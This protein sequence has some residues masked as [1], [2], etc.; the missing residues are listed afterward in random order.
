MTVLK[1][2]DAPIESRWNREA[3]YASWEDWQA[4]YEQTVAALPELSNY[5][6]RLKEG[7]QVLA[8]WF[9]VYAQHWERVII[10]SAFAGWAIT[11]DTS[12]EE[13]R[14]YHSQSAGLESE[15]R[16]MAAFMD[17][18]L[19]EIGDTLLDWADKEEKLARFRHYFSNLLR[20]RE[21]RRSAE[22]E[23][24]LNMADQ[25]FEGVYRAYSELVN[26][27][28]KFEDAI[29][30]QGG[31]HPIFQATVL[32]SNES[33]DRERRLSA[34][35]NY[36]DS[37]ISMENTLAS[38]Y[39]ANVKQQIFLMKA[40][41]FN[42]VL[43]MRL[44]PNNLPVE[45][46]HNLINTFKKNLPLWR[47]Y[48]QAKGKVL[49]LAEMRPY[50]ILAPIQKTPPKI[51]YGQ[52][53]EWI[54]AA[55]EPMGEDYVNAMRRGALEDRWV[56]YAPNI[57][58]RQGAASSRQVGRK[59]P[60]IFMSYNDSVINLS[61]LAHELGHSMHSRYFATNQPFVYNDY[62]AISSTVTETASNFNQAMTRAYL[63]KEKADD[64]GL[65]L[66]MVDEAMSNFYR[67]FFVM[68][69]LARFEL[70]VYERAQAGK[71]LTTTDLKEIMGRLFGEGYGETLRDD[72]ERTAITWAKFL[73]LYIPF[74]SFQYAI[75]ISA[76]HAASDKILLGEEGAVEGYQNFLKAG[77]SRYA[78]DLF[79]L[80]GVDMSSAEPIEKAF[81]EMERNVELLEVMAGS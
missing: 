12:D 62:G 56:D 24:I 13:A 34:W 4:E 17:P 73:H 25:P 49:G 55:L 52:A 39:L 14:R 77:G 20:L 64:K 27:D 68:P 44:S 67:Y 9:E 72:P 66:A 58:K 65:Q 51:P 53:V 21:H 54:C 57:E 43:E 32:S 59:P 37:F 19:L 76:A 10:L 50:D 31:A 48:W 69:T 5:K 2:K 47:R 40:R 70:E 42:S 23:E 80:A 18:E 6:G 33:H 16:A 81:K 35:E 60:Y 3:V 79:S 61:T 63:R 7:P 71:P 36:T 22:V 78:I 41:G 11:V 75:G 26:T 28:L 8:E 30:S 74:Y 45:V 38:L 15:M 1:R 29:D 46:F